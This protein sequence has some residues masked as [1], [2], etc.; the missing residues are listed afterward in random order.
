MAEDTNIQWCDD[1]VNPIEGCGGCELFP[2]PQQITAR[3][4]QVLI[5]RNI[6]GWNSGSARQM[7]ADVIDEGWQQMLQEFPEPGI[8]HF[9]AVTTTNIYHFRERFA[10]R[11]SQ[12]CGKEAGTAAL[13]II[14]RDIKCY[15][16]KLHLNRGY[17][18]LN[19]TRKPNRGY[20]PT[21]EQ[22]TQFP[23]RMEQIARRP[24]LLGQDRP[25]APWKN[26]LA[27]LIFIS[28]MGDALSRK[29]DF[30]FLCDEL[31]ETQTDDGRRH[32]WL[33]LTKRPEMMREFASRN[34]GLPDNICAMTTVTSDETLSR[35][36]TLRNTDAHSR[37]LSLEP[38]W[39]SVAHKLDL[40]GIDW[41]IVGGESGATRHVSPFYVE[42][43]EE[44][45]ALCQ[46]QGVAYFLKQ[47]GR[48]PIRNSIEI[49]LQDSHGG[50]W[51]EW[52]QDLRIRAFPRYFQTYR[53]AEK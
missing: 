21:F 45:Q 19:P 31:E 10:N 16:A 12:I 18:V 35:V 41:V 52:D 44:I 20:A 23:G 13:D 50:D 26:G 43:A 49:S 40:T 8:G 11:V 22:V 4:D 24:D 28:D 3:I 39:S 38:L 34:H 30:D 51:D 7:F 9:N 37:G 15:A 1:T 29:D 5:N 27:R 48:R 33:W 36:E 14:H 53:Q 47:L 32:L 46:D 42:W 25:D 6:K 17:S 2:K